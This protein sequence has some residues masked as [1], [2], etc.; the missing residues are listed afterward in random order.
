[1]S[2]FTDKQQKVIDHDYGNIVVSASAGSGKTSV[3]I[4][5]L[6]RLISE[7]K[8]SVRNILAVTF[9]RLA[10]GEMREKLSRAIIK[11]IQQGEDVARMRKELNDLPFAT[12]ST[13]DS[14]LNTLVSKYFYLVGVDSR[15]QIVA[16]SQAEA[17]K[18]LAMSEVFERLYDSDDKD[19]NLL[20]RAFITKR[21]D[22]QL[23]KLI[24][25]VYTFLE[26]QLEPDKFLSS[27]LSNYTQAGHEMAEN[28]LIGQLFNQVNDIND[29]LKGL[30]VE[31]LALGCTKYSDYLSQICSNVDNCEKTPAGILQVVKAIPKKPSKQKTDTALILDLSERI[32]AYVK[33]L[34]K[35]V[36]DCFKYFGIDKNLRLDRTLKNK[37]LLQS[38]IN[39][40]KQFELEYAKQKQEQNLL[41][42]ADLARCAY[43]LLQNKEVIDDIK[44]TYKYIFVDEYQDTNGVQEGIFRL[45]EQNNLFIVGDVKQSIYGFRGCDSDIFSNR[46]DEAKKGDF[47]VGLDTNFRSA[48]AVVNAVNKVFSAVM[49]NESMGLDYSKAPMIYGNLY[50]DYKGEA[51]IY[52][53]AGG[54]KTVQKLDGVYSVEKHLKAQK[55]TAVKSEVLVR[56]LVQKALNK[57]IIDLKTGEKRLANYGDIAILTRNNKGIADRIAKELDM[58]GIPVIS[59]SKRSI[60]DYPEIQLIVNILTLIY[61]PG[62]DIALATTLKSPL[63]GFTDKDLLTIREG[64]APKT[65]FFEAVNKS[66]TPSTP[67]GV[68]LIE[69]LDKINK[70]RLVSKFEGVPSILNR[71]MADGTFESKLLSMRGGE[72]KIKRIQRFIQECFKGD[73]EITVGEFLSSSEELLDKMTLSSGGGEDAVKIMSMHA[74]KGLEFPICIIAGLNDNWNRQDFRMEVMLDKNAGVGLKYYDFETKAHYTTAIRECVKL[75]KAQ[76]NLK[77][78]LRLMYVALTRAK[79]ILYVVPQKPLEDERTPITSST[80][81]HLDLFTKTDMEYFELT[82]N[83]LELATYKKERRALLL[84]GYDDCDVELIKKYQS[85]E[86]AHLDETKLSLKKSV[87]ESVK[88]SNYEDLPISVERPVVLGASDTETGTAYHKAL[89]LV[90]FA[91]SGDNGYIDRL[92]SENFD[93]ATLKKLTKDKLN[94]ILALDIFKEIQGFKLYKEQPFIAYVPAQMV[95]ETGSENV[96]LQGVIDLLAVNGDKAYVIDYKHSGANKQTLKERYKVQLDLYAYAVEKVLKLKVEK[97]VIVN[98]SR[99]ETVEL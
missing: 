85:F 82:P 73:A 22:A 55:Q 91:K 93:E 62:N 33:R 28:R 20:M 89:E 35:V 34:K 56:F 70:L 79:C 64:S 8:A 94:Q 81:S 47:H 84:S 36:D 1:M 11:K 32:S 87:T 37:A 86:Y 9:T 74:S 40:V 16:E 38:L 19:L 57:S 41:D 2:K 15:Y 39:V 61:S 30:L 25:S 67:L 12:I 71:I 48:P 72:L 69:F 90:D 26:S 49:T 50:G 10:A 14:F 18:T 4:E 51:E 99:L 3:M 83:D 46:I 97:R 58:A 98:I 17:L 53:L 65:S 29:L 21:S 60:S 42:Y 96:L 5:R 54:E 59:E 45:L 75:K 23:R 6:I 76:S 52:T 88:A 68:R 44:N 43:K 7:G 31:A 24:L 80:N 63:G 27:A 92:L 13:I 95:G 77:D 78:E 66:A